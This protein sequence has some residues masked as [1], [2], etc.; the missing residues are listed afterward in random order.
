MVELS[1]RDPRK[2]YVGISRR[3]LWYDTTMQP[4]RRWCREGPFPNASRVSGR[5]RPWRIP[6]SD[7]EGFEL[8]KMGGDVLSAQPR[9]R[10]RGNRRP[11]DG[12]SEKG[13]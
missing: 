11:G 8:P 13:H 4:I 1:K 7:L 10:R 12:W 3:S 5:H 6:E 2:R 9:A